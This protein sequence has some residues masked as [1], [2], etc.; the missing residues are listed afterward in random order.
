MVG[1][2]PPV[3]CCTRNMPRLA[4]PALLVPMTDFGR[5]LV[6]GS[7]PPVTCWTRA[8]PVSWVLTVPPVRFV[9]TGLILLNSVVPVFWFRTGLIERPVRCG[10]RGA[11]SGATLVPV[12]WL[13]KLT[14]RPD[15]S[16][17]GGGKKSRP[18]APEVVPV[19]VGE[20]ARAGDGDAFLEGE[21]S[22]WNS[23]MVRAC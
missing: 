16:A 17:R 20:R 4:V 13:T 14:N 23:K 10:D 19:S 22:T 15:D 1:V 8:P 18:Y 5:G 21:R 12:Y 11:S 3:I 2:A 6:T 7:P 9:F